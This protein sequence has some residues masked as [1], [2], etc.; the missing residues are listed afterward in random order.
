MKSKGF[1]VKGISEELNIKSD[2]IAD[3]RNGRKIPTYDFLTKMEENL[4]LIEREGILFYKTCTS[5]V[6]L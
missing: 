1:K 2:I 4:Q 5:L 6:I 3:F